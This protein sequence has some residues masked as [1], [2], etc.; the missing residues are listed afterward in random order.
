M[1]EGNDRRHRDRKKALA[2]GKKKERW[3]KR[4]KEGVEGRDQWHMEKESR[5]RKRKSWPRRVCV[6]K[7]AKERKQ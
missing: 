2:Q 3:S 4:E 6:R 5:G 7:M 1:V